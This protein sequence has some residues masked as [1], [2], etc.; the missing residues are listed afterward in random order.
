MNV[1]QKSEPDVLAGHDGSTTTVIIPVLEETARIERRQVEAGLV[2]V[3]KTVSEREDVV[4]AL[5]MQEDLHVERIPINR[6]VAQAP[7]VR[8]EGDVLIVPVMEEVL[9]VEKRLMLKEEL[10]IRRTRGERSVR[11]SVRL[12]TESVAVEQTPDASSFPKV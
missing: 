6:V 2:R 8:E 12:R 3:H 1:D 4:E 5:L 7:S 11:E 10:R 9:V